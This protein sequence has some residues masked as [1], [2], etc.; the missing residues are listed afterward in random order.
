MSIIFYDFNI[1]N[2]PSAWCPRRFQALFKQADAGC[3]ESACLSKLNQAI[4]QQQN[5]QPPMQ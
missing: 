2:Y 5:F 4:Q 1:W 3:L